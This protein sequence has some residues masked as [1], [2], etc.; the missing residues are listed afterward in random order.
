MVAFAS[1]LL[2]LLFASTLLGLLA[3][4]WGTFVLPEEG[5]G[6][7]QPARGVAA[8]LHEWPW[9]LITIVGAVVLVLQIAG[10]ALCL[11]VPRAWKIRGPEAA[12]L[13]LTVVGLALFLAFYIARLPSWVGAVLWALR[14]VVP[15][16]HLIYVSNLV[17]RIDQADLGERADSVMMFMLLLLVFPVLFPIITPLIGLGRGDLGFI[18]VLVL[19]GLALVFDLWVFARLVN[20]HLAVYHGIFRYRESFAEKEKLEKAGWRDPPGL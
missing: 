4:I 15:A 9:T 8:F 12:A 14:L 18:L 17:P 20:L 1:G 2:W 11:A 16:L 19:L 7:V 6:V 5:R 13:G 3:G 10:H